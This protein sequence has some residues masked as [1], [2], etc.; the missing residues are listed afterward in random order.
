MGRIATNPTIIDDL[1]QLPISKLKEL[2]YLTPNSQKGGT[3]TW[4]RNGRTSGEIYIQ[5]NISNENPYIELNYNYLGEP[6]KY[7]VYLMTVPSNLGKGKVWLF[8]CPHTGKKCRKLFLISG[9]FL[10]REALKGGMYNSQ[11][12]SKR[13]RDLDKFF[14]VFRVAEKL[15]KKHFKKMYANQPTKKYLKINKILNSIDEPIE[16]ML[17]KFL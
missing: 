10:H 9:Y 11:V 14:K 7:K 2:K 13:S 5:T 16:D 17:L 15:K 8:V 4:T 6:R 12:K 1:L 3:L